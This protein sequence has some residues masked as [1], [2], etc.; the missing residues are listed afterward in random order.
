M[1]FANGD[2]AL[3][4][5][6]V[7]WKLIPLA[8]D[9]TTYSIACAK[10][11]TIYVGGAAEIGYLDVD[12]QG[13]RSYVSLLPKINSKEELGFAKCFKELHGVSPSAFKKNLDQK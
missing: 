5:D 13:K 2:G 8:N 1:Y 11:Q 6:G 12:A 3:I 9:G 4:Y 7:K 10:D